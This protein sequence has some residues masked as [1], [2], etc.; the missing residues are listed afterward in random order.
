MAISKLIPGMKP[1]HRTRN[2]AIA[3]G[4]LLTIG[5]WIFNNISIVVGTLVY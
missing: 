3:I 1:G 5:A 2:I 4:Y